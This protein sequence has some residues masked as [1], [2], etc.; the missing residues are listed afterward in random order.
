MVD[1]FL[2][3]LPSG[4]TVLAVDYQQALCNQIRSIENS[5]KPLQFSFID[6]SFL[7]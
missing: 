6:T 7:L 4:K 2:S 3:D 1:L 5:F